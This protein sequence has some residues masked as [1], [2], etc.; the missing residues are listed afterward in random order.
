MTM[1]IIVECENFM[2]KT[3]NIKKRKNVKFDFD[4]V[5]DESQIRNNIEI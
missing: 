1:Q 5:K 2:T 4:A 3:T